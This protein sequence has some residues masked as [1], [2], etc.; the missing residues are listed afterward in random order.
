MT[1]SYKIL[2]LVFTALWILPV[3]YVAIVGKKVPFLGKYLNHQY[4]VSCLFT[5]RMKHWEGHYVE[6]T[7]YHSRKISHYPIHELTDFTL[8]ST[9]CRLN[10]M[11]NRSGFSRKDRRQLT[12]EIITYLKERHE[13]KHPV[14]I[15]SI[16]IIKVLFP[17]GIPELSNPKG[18]WSL[19]EFDKIPSDYQRTVGFLRFPYHE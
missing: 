5:R 11:L 19:P 17:V 10:R 12:N 18:A 4:Q 13:N 7:Y 1:M 6:I 16:R 8:H 2:F 3:S 9:V 14:K 15:R